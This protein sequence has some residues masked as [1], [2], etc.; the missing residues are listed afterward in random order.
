MKGLSDIFGGRRHR[1]FSGLLLVLLLVFLLDLL[2]VDRIFGSF[3][4]FYLFFALLIIFY[5][6]YPLYVNRRL[7]RYYWVRTKRHHLAVI[8]LSFIIFL[9]AVAVKDGDSIRTS[10]ATSNFAYAD[11]PIALKDLNQNVQKLAVQIAPAVPVALQ[12]VSAPAET[13]APAE[14]VDDMV[15]YAEGEE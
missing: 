10:C 11:I 13:T 15:V 6:I 4:Y 1:L 7:T 9:V 8:G 12:N 5:G 3:V 2:V 14:S